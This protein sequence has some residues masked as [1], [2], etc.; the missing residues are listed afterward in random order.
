MFQY[1]TLAALAGLFLPFQSLIAARTASL[2]NGPMMAALVNFAGG[3]IACIVLI[4]LFRIPWPSAEQTAAVPNY[5][6]LT[7]LFGAFF[8]AQ[9]AFTVPKLGAAG[10]IAI[11]VA[12][13]MIG[14]IVLDHFGI[15][16]SVQ[17]M[18]VQKLLGAVLLCVGAYLILQPG[19]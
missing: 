19:R 16:Q 11:V 1:V 13:Q 18:T 6:W 17:P 12:G 15:M 10:M 7:G 8:V 4:V 5:G 9:A 3:T 2:I 14:S